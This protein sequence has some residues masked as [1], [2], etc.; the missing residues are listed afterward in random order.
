MAEAEEPAAA[1]TAAVQVQEV[2]TAEADH[3]VEQE[4]N[5]IQPFKIAL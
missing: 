1:I 3:Q 4:D 5:D 2:D